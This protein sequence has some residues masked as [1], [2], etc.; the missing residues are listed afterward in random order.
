MEPGKFLASILFFYVAAW[1]WQVA[2]VL[3]FSSK[4]EALA[5][6]DQVHMEILSSQHKELSSLE[7]NL[8]TTRLKVLSTL[9]KRLKSVKAMLVETA[10]RT[11]SDKSRVQISTKELL[12]VVDAVARQS[13][14]DV[15][16]QEKL[17][18][19]DAV[20]LEHNQTEDGLAEISIVETMDITT[21]E[22]SKSIELQN[23]QEF[24]LNTLL[25]K[26]LSTE[27]NLS[28]HRIDDKEALNSSGA[29]SNHWLIPSVV[30]L[31]QLD[32]YGVCQGSCHCFLS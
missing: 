19:N 3:I 20:Q 13:N 9:K 2:E 5:N 31:E 32:R 7:N 4:E 15:L 26:F 21:E 29:S 30:A 25:I 17:I 28:C 23:L 12:S 8:K 18:P 27:F 1:R 24:D 11:Y 10:N 14:P 6:A 16:I 22:I